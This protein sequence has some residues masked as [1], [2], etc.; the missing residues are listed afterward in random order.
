[1]SL[2]ME[3]DF[4]GDVACLDADLLQLP[5]V[6]P[7]AIKANPYVAEKLF[8]QWLSFTETTSLVKLYS[9]PMIGFVALFWHPFPLTLLSQ[10]NH[11]W[12]W[13][14]FLERVGLESLWIGTRWGRDMWGWGLR[15]GKQGNREDH[16][17]LDIY[18]GPTLRINQLY[19]WQMKIASL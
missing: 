16:A 1:M 14:L 7:L 5:E 17:T 2:S 13:Y 10:R 4:T 9:H 12:I 18:S 19:N 15:I 11:L 6:S 3:L 8:D